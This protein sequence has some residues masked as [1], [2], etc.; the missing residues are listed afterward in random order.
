MQIL[1]SIPQLDI[2]RLKAGLMGLEF[3]SHTFTDGLGQKWNYEL[4]SFTFSQI[5]IIGESSVTLRGD[6][7]LVLKTVAGGNITIHADMNLDGGDA[8]QETGYGGRPC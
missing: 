5:S 7:P 2:F 8:S 3:S 6:K 4:C 1:L